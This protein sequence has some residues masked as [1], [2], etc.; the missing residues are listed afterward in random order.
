M[1]N[2]NGAKQ[3]K[4]REGYDYQHVECGRF[5]GKYRTTH[6][7]SKAGLIGFTKSVAREVANRNV[8]KRSCQRPVESD[9]TAVLS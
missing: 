9:M 8:R 6:A 2:D 7:A 5:D 4:A 1:L 3:I